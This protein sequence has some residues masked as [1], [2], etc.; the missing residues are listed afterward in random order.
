[1][2]NKKILSI[3]LKNRTCG[4]SIIV[5]LSN[6]KSQIC[7]LD[8]DIENIIQD[9]TQ[10]FLKD[11]NKNLENKLKSIEMVLDIDKDIERKK[12]LS[13]LKEFLQAYIEVIK[14]MNEFETGKNDIEQILK[15]K[16]SEN[17]LKMINLTNNLTVYEEKYNVIL[18]KLS[19]IIQNYNLEKNFKILVS[20]I[21]KEKI[22]YVQYI[23]N[24]LRITFGEL[25]LPREIIYF[26]YDIEELKK[27]ILEEYNLGEK[28]NIKY[29]VDYRYKGIIKDKSFNKYLNKLNLTFKNVEEV[30][31][32]LKK[33]YLLYDLNCC[34][35]FG[36]YLNM[37][38][39]IYAPQVM[40]LSSYYSEYIARK[41]F[42]K[43]KKYY[44][45]EELNSDIKFYLNKINFK[46]DEES[47]LI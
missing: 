28:S 10:N 22:P 17:L 41:V 23:I 27:Q 19:N 18:E 39:K 37:L 13:S 36:Q 33:V 31:R 16:K 15:L 42:E 11:E 5:D 1:M 3:N 32:Q 45:M 20:D 7:Y 35:N 14:N 6:S 25:N 4:N 30:T 24:E 44:N 38:S 9:L 34:I 47:I 46:I 8:L 21:T 2:Q 29:L 12:Q 26:L 43:H 40:N